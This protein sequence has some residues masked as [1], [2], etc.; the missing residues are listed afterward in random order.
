MLQS[1]DFPSPGRAARRTAFIK[2][3]PEAAFQVHAA[4]AQKRPPRPSLDGTSG[5]MKSFGS[6]PAAFPRAGR[7]GV[8]DHRANVELVDLGNSSMAK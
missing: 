8:P 4:L 2:N 5:T 1:E 7:I 6:G 3:V